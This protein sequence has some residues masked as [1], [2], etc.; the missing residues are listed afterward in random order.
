VTGSGPHGGDEEVDRLPF[1]ITDVA[2]IH[3]V[4]VVLFLALTLLTLATL[5]RARA[6]A[7]VLRRGEVL[8]GVIVAQAAVGYTQYFTGVPV[9]L[10][11]I[12]IAGAVAV[13]TATLHFH[14]GL[15]QRVAEP[16][17]EPAPTPEVGSTVLTSAMP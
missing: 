5:L 9:L 1:R 14:L 17:P 7:A 15:T 12:H 10:V 13:W 16:E 11:G 2:R 4:A 8:L 3:G 6:P